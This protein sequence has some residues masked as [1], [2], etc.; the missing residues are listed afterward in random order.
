MNICEL[1]KEMKSLIEDLTDD[2]GRLRMMIDKER[3]QF[4]VART[5]LNDYK[6]SGADK[7][8]YNSCQKEYLDSK[9]AIKR[10]LAGIDDDEYLAYFY[11]LERSGGRTHDHVK[12]VIEEK[13]NKKIAVYCTDIPSTCTLNVEFKEYKLINDNL[14]TILKVFSIPYASFIREVIK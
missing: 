7:R 6:L 13:Y 11:V 5:V 2:W 10:K 4:L 8:F 12:N 1:M 3:L 14:L 9:E